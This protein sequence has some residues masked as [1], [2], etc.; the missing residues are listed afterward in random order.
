MDIPRIDAKDIGDAMRRGERVV[1][2]D[3]R[4][5]KSWDAATEQI[6][7]SIRIAPEDIDRRGA[8]L[9]AGPIT[10]SYCT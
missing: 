1:F 5:V 3:S 7:G 6:P 8:E 2:V 10:V 4:S 9:P